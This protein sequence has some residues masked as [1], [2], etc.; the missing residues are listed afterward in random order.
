MALTEWSLDQ[1]MRAD[2]LIVLGL[3]YL[4][5]L[6]SAEIKPQYEYDRR[7][8]FVVYAEIYMDPWVWQVNAVYADGSTKEYSSGIQHSVLYFSVRTAS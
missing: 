3:I 5:G 1:A 6:V 4:I 8:D 2:D 7:E